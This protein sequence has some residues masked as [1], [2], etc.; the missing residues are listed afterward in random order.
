[1]L[2]GLVI[3]TSPGTLTSRPATEMVQSAVTHDLAEDWRSNWSPQ[4]GLTLHL[5]GS[6]ILHHRGRFVA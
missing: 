5:K 4:P 2:G 3:R 1:M 6:R